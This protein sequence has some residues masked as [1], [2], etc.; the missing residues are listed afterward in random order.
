MKKFWLLI[1]ICLLAS[2]FSLTLAEDQINI[3]ASIAP[4]PTDLEL[5]YSVSPPENSL[6]YQ[7]NEEIIITI[8]YRSLI[9]GSQPLNL[10]LNYPLGRINDS[11]TNLINAL[12]YVSLSST[13]SPE[14]AVPIIDLINRSISWQINS[15]IGSPTNSEV[16]LKLKV[17][18]NLSNEQIYNDLILSAVFGS[19]T[20]P[21]QEQTL[22]L[23]SPLIIPTPTPTALPT[24]TSTPKPTSAEKT[25]TTTPT[26][27][28]T[29]TAT[30]TSQLL[31]N[32]IFFKEITN[33]TATIV[34]QTNVPSQY[35]LYYGQQSNNLNERE[36]YNQGHVQQHQIF[37]KNL[38]PQQQ[39]FFRFLLIGENNTS[40]WSDL[41]TFTTAKQQ[42]QFLVVKK[43][44][45]I[46]WQQIPLA[47]SSQQAVII[48]TQSANTIN[49]KAQK[50]KL[51]KK[52]ILKYVNKQVLGIF[53][54]KPQIAEKQVEMLEILPGTYSATLQTPSNPGEYQLTL[55]ITDIYNGFYIQV[56]E[57]QIYVAKPFLVYDALNQ[58]PIEKARVKIYRY[59]KSN[60]LFSL[61]DHAYLNDL[62]TNNKGELNINLP[63]G[64]YRFEISAAGYLPKTDFVY[65]LD[66]STKAYPQIKL[67]KSNNLFDRLSYYQDTLIDL[68]N[69]GW[70]VNQNLANSSR[71]LNTFL[72]MTQILTLILGLGLLSHRAGFNPFTK[73]FHYKI[74]SSKAAKKITIWQ[75]S[76]ELLIQLISDLFIFLNFAIT[77]ILVLNQGWL[78]NLGYVITSVLLLIFWFVY[79]YQE[80]VSRYKTSSPKL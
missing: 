45:S 62:Y 19:I 6:Y 11:P 49:I 60:Q 53:S 55:E 26:P 65:R 58:Q 27:T 25:T 48:N 28:L 16:S 80:H 29:P 44:L 5:S 47:Q 8:S 66:K 30:P 77:L 23:F 22:E 64:R 20:L 12:G 2:P 33:N 63:V 75:F 1:L 46:V 32:Q 18:E 4:K 67:T 7:A 42:K 76:E 34:A 69:Y 31:I 50:P 21:D 61:F 36:V 9:E 43:D 15:I 52:I 68:G 24:P 17:L 38:Q 39:Y 37:L 35:T 13:T 56:L 40:V 73:L 14:G 41:Y 74:K 51:I 3:S 71:A 57:N 59:S 70:E 79:N 78:T 72:K 10:S 54:A